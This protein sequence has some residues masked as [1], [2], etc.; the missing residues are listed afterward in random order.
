MVE[1][2]PAS[3]GIMEQGPESCISGAVLVIALLSTQLNLGNANG[4]AGPAAQLCPCQQDWSLQAG[5]LGLLHTA[6]GLRLL[7]ATSTAHTRDLICCFKDLFKLFPSPHVKGGLE[8]LMTI[9][10]F[11]TFCLLPEQTAAVLSAEYH[12]EYFHKRL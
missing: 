10:T 3:F 6:L 7:T 5:L 12:C 11:Q 9:I 2:G 8:K 1:P 4:P